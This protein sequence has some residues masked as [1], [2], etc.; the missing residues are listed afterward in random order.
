MPKFLIKLMIKLQIF[1]YKTNLKDNKIK[2]DIREDYIIREI[3]RKFL[4]EKLELFTLL[5]IEEYRNDIEEVIKIFQEFLEEKDEL[6][7][8]FYFLIY[9][10][11]ILDKLKI[12]NED[13]LNGI[14][15]KDMKSNENYFIQINIQ[16]NKAFDYARILYWFRNMINYFEDIIPKKIAIIDLESSII[17]LY[18]RYYKKI[19]KNKDKIIIFLMLS[20]KCLREVLRKIYLKFSNQKFKTLYD[21]FLFYDNEINIDIENEEIIIPNKRKISLKDIDNLDIKNIKKE[22]GFKE[23]NFSNIIKMK[24][25]LYEEYITYYYPNALYKEENLLQIFWFFNFFIRK[26]INDD[27]FQ[28]IIPIELNEFNLVID[29]ILRENKKRINTKFKDIIKLGYKLLEGINHVKKDEIGFSDGLDLFKKSNIETKVD[30]AL[31]TIETI[32]NYLK[33]YMNNKE[34]WA[35]IED[36]IKMLEKSKENYVFEVKKNTL[37]KRLNILESYIK[38]DEKLIFLENDIKYIR[39]LISQ[40]KKYKGN[41]K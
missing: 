11:E 8:Y 10:K 29:Y 23:N 26:Y 20:N 18:Y 28:K 36:K 9:L 38:R 5:E 41:R 40:K 7:Q 34:L 16:K 25:D 2:K 30:I 37:T 3:P 39:N 21:I 33:E 13:K 19:Y 12:I 32:K 35:S 27:D 6:Y 22:F 14:K 4:I 31:E 17:C 1:K 15:I 24:K